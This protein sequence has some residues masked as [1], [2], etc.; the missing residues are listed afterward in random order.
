MA[1]VRGILVALSIAF[2]CAACSL[3]VSTRHRCL[4]W[5]ERREP[6]TDDWAAEAYHK[7]GVYSYGGRIILSETACN[8]IDL[9]NGERVFWDLQEIADGPGFGK[10]IRHETYRRAWCW[11]RTLWFPYWL[12]VVLSSVLPFCQLISFARKHRPRNNGTCCLQ[13]GYDL[14]ASTDRCPECGT[15]IQSTMHLEG[16]TATPRFPPPPVG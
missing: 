9:N 5:E 6:V 11:H 14:R 7:R 8:A 1:I 12:I 13:C 2:L 15:A 16:S 3:W 4:K 10:I